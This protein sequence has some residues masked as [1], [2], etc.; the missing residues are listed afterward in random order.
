MDILIKS[1]SVLH[2][3][4][5]TVRDQVS[6]LP[7]ELKWQLKKT[8]SFWMLMIIAIANIST[9]NVSAYRINC[10]Y[11]FL[12]IYLIKEKYRKGMTKFNKQTCM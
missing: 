8:K 12:M 4:P 3:N 7:N 10:Y 11:I 2:L 6:A 1:L 5:G 9:E